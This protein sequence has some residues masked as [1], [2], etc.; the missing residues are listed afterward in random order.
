MLFTIAIPTY[1]S[2]TTVSNAIKSALDQDYNEEY[3]VLIVNNASTDNTAKII[4][5]FVDKRIR[6]VNNAKTV[7]L[8]QNHNVCFKE[9]KGD[10][11]L[12]CHS[13]DRLQSSALSILSEEIKR[14]FHP[15]RLIIWGESMFRD[16]Y[17]NFVR[18]GHEI[19][20]I[21]SGIT[22]NK[23][24]I[25]GGLTPSG[26]CYSREAILEIGGFDKMKSRITPMDWYIMQLAAFNGFEFEML[27]RLL[28]MRTHASTANS[29]IT[30][31]DWVS[32]EN[33]S[34]NCLL[35]H[36]S[37]YQ[38]QVLFQCFY[39]DGPIQAYPY[40]KKHISKT[41]K[42]KFLLKRFLRDPLHFRINLKYA[43]Y[44]LPEE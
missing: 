38:Q 20:T 10:Y 19:N 42:M 6:I 36:L 25:H 23:A 5:T 24:F 3:E 22:A 15:K 40:I 29:S 27:D 26:T 8:F 11:V 39:S 33:D 21:I 35:A 28:F 41:C 16:Y 1:N 18:S 31:K 4:A 34:L 9:A 30:W 17:D 2:E 37:K 43:T 14:R 32:A 44:K 12:F 13:D 7:D